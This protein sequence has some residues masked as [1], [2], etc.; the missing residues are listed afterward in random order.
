MTGNFVRFGEGTAH[1][2]PPATAEFEDAPE[3]GEVLRR[4]TFHVVDVHLLGVQSVWV[5]QDGVE[6][7]GP[8]HG[9]SSAQLSD[10]LEV[11]VT[12]ESGEFIQRLHVSRGHWIVALRFDTNRHTSLPERWANTPMNYSESKLDD[13]R[14]AVGFYGKTG[15]FHAYSNVIRS[16]GLLTAAVPR[17][18]QDHQIYEAL[19]KE[20]RDELSAANRKVRELS[21]QLD[22]KETELARSRSNEEAS[23]AESERS[24][25][26]I[27]RLTSEKEAINAEFAAFKKG[28]EDGAVSLDDIVQGMQEQLKRT[29]DRINARE[30]HKLGRVSVEFRLVPDAGGRYRFP[31]LLDDTGQ[32]K[33][34]TSASALSSLSLEFEDP[35]PKPPEAP[36]KRVVPDVSGCTDVMATR[37][38]AA[39][40]FAVEAHSEVV[41][42][43]RADREGRVVRQVPP[44]GAEEALGAKV[45]VF[46]GK[47]TSA[48]GG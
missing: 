34:G 16:I 42:R 12:L 31:Q 15:P 29:R 28:K 9:M 7:V 41:D 20:V 26:S 25:E 23:R 5:N 10:A 4:V 19:L 21:E 35:R 8:L 22:R 17:W 43:A 45:M 33:D 6:R 48:S 3:N 46:F 24:Q 47:L 32:L 13:D 14:M 40:G 18:A 36:P 2:G 39:A 27:S 11:S 38:L 30:D 44:A 1:S 37:L